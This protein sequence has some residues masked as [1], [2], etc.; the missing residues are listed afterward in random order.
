MQTTEEILSSA[1][2][3]IGAIASRFGISPAQAHSAIG[4]LLPAVLGGMQKKHAEGNLGAVTGAAAEMDQ[5]NAQGGNNILADILGSKD[6]SREVA[7]HAATS[8]SGVSSSVLKAMLPVVA[9][10]VAKHLA[11]S[12][13]A[14]GGIGGVLGSLLQHQSGGGGL[15]NLGSALSEGGSLLGGILGH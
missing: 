7:D 10:M 15:G 13:G 2:T 1:G 4:S 8:T 3:D 9:A 6:V 11:V 12:G 5:L 14:N